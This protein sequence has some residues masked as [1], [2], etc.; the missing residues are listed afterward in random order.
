M[1]LPESQLI[2]IMRA[3]KSFA[4]ICKDFAAIYLEGPFI[5]PSKIGAQNPAYI[6][7]PSAEMLSRLQAESGGLIKIAVVAPEVEGGLQFIEEASKFVKVSVAHTVCDYGTAH[8]AFRRG[9]AQMTHLYNAMN[10][11]NHRNPGPIIAAAENES[12]SVEL[13]CDGVHVHPAVVRNTFRMFGAD[14]IIFISDSMEAAGMPDGDYELGGQKV[15][16]KGRLATLEDC[17]TIA[18]SVTNLMD[19]MRTAVIEMNIPLESAVKCAAINSAKAIGLDA[20]IH[21]GSRANLCALDKNLNL[22]WVMNDGKMIY[23][24]PERE[25]ISI[26]ASLSAPDFAAV[27]FDFSDGILTLYPESKYEYANLDEKSF[28]AGIDRKNNKKLLFHLPVPIS[29]KGIYLEYPFIHRININPD[30]FIEDFHANIHYTDMNFF[31]PELE[32]FYPSLSMAAPDYVN[33]TITFKTDCK[34]AQSFKISI[35][36]KECSINFMYGTD[37]SYGSVS[38]ARTRTFIN[39]NFAPTEDTDF[40]I[41]VS[42]VIYNVFAFICNRKNI[43]P[44]NIHLVGNNNLSSRLVIIRKYQEPPE[45]I[46]VIE[47]TTPNVNY[48]MPNLQKLFQLIADGNVSIASLNAS[49]R[50]R[51]LIGLQQ[52][53][54]ITAA[55][56]EYVRKYIPNM[57]NSDDEAA[58]KINAWLE[59]LKSELTGSSKKLAAN[60]LR[61]FKLSQQLSLEQK[62]IKVFNGYETDSGK[63][64]SLKTVMEQFGV[65]DI[66][67]LAKEINDWRNDLAHGKGKYV[68]S[69]G[70]AAAVR[71]VER[72][73]YC[74]VLRHLGYDDRQIQEILRETFTKEW[75]PAAPDLKEIE[76]ALRRR[77]TCPD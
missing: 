49:L 72:M 20:H 56:E 38:S 57:R 21:S 17:K 2:H 45:D 35:S 34:T 54:G 47:K 55:F 4:K 22:V 62:I 68:P 3:A 32:H 9:A 13:I 31:F 67:S 76:D 63:W 40:L 11:I 64:E 71:L 5:S 44:Q 33:K 7:R 73:N 42:R 29:L 25:K 6:V 1:T 26:A 69:E 52:S 48:Y 41:A 24:N 66:S 53:L 19:C 28:V 61:G 74:I 10:P 36:A 58:E 51:N 27:N 43:T 46:A 37:C 65:E 23:S 8:E 30:W 18:G 59:N 60:L 12:V 77:F 70:T 14:R 16:K 39:V 15:I 75:K 50:L